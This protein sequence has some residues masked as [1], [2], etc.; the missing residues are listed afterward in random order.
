[1]LSSHHSKHGGVVQRHHELK[2]LPAQSVEGELGRVER[3][4]AERGGRLEAM[5]QLR[6]RRAGVRTAERPTAVA[7][8]AAPC[9]SVCR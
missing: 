3:H 5:V 8:C 6:T 4:G 2:Q 9:E 7:R 1:V